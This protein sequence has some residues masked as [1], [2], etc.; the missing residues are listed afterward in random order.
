MENVHE[1]KVV[2]QVAQVSITT[3]G[4]TTC[5]H[6]RFHG[7]LPV[8]ASDV[9]GPDGVKRDVLGYDDR[10]A[11]RLAESNLAAGDMVEMTNRYLDHPPAWG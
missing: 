6:I 10:Y 9:T 11:L 3:D 1:V 5:Q 4:T 2:N 8:N 7:Q